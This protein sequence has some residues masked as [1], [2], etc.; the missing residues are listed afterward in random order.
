MAGATPCPHPQTDFLESTRWTYLTGACWG[1]ADSFTDPRGLPQ[2]GSGT[3][4]SASQGVAGPA[5]Q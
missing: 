2:L 3:R 1:R 5:R 4:P